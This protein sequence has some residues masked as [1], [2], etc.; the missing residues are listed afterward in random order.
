MRGMWWILLIPVVEA[1]AQSPTGRITGRV[2]DATGAAIPR[3]AVR[4]IDIRTNVETS[5]VTTGEGVYEILNLIPGRYRLTANLKGFKSYERGPL[6]VRVGDA[7]AVDI[8]L[9]VGEVA[10]RVTVHGEAPLLEA[11]SA[12]ISQVVD[13]R[14][15]QDL[16][17][18]N[19]NIIFLL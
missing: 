7:L 14:R 10:E 3:A 6:E 8:G 12:T 1:P 15:I 13:S 11:T 17:I 4:A 9:E 18:P 5:A 2:T 19:G 16:H